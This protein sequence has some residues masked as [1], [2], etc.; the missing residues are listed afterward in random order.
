MSAVSLLRLDR[1]GGVAPGNK[2]FKLIANWN[3]A[4]AQ[5][6]TRLVSF[7]GSW[8]NHLHALAALGAEQGFATVGIVRGDEAREN[9]AMLEDARSFGME[10]ITVSREEYRRRYDTAYVANIVQRFRPCMIVPEGGANSAGVAGCTA[11]ADLIKHHAPD[12]EHV[13]L[14]VGT[15]TTLAG[16]VAGLGKGYRVTGVSALKGASDME[17]K[18]NAYLQP[19]CSN[20]LARWQL[21]HDWHCGGFAKVSKALKRFMLA[22]EDVQGVPLEPIYTGKVLYAIHQQLASAGWPSDEP[23]LAVH[24][25]GLQGRRGYPWLRP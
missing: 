11:I 13:V 25:G 17:S 1:L 20:S 14:G 3:Q 16:L 12:D 5:G 10:V 23:V 9:T 2:C 15:G 18:I 7:G 8:S 19:Y 6:L 21:V 4:K 24:T 22:F